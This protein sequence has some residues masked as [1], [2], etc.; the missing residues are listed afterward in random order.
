MSYIRLPSS[1][2]DTI[3]AKLSSVNITSAA[4]F[5]TSVPTFPIAH[6]M[7]DVFN[8]GLSFTPSPV[9]ATTSPF[10]C[11]AFT[12][13]T[14]C[15]GDT[16]A[17]TEYFLISFVNCSSDILSSSNP[18]KASSSFS[19]IP[20]FLAIATAVTLWSPV[21]ITVLIPACLHFSTAFLAS[22]LGGSIIPTI[23]INVNPLSI[24]FISSFD[25]I[26]SI[27]LYANAKTLNASFAIFSLFSL[28][29]FAYSSKFVLISP[30]NRYELHIFNNSSTPPFV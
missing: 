12:I 27:S 11:H 10:A 4:S 5:A 18:V 8:A 2:A 7:S 29:Q 3:V 23:P 9:M 24:V 1:T 19:N 17:Y 14:L 28:I 21:I 6:P 25:G 16:L 30:L 26:W 22:S 13:R 15:S 20:N